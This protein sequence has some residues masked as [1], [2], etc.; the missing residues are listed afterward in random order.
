[1]YRIEDNISAIKEL[2]RLLGVNES[3]F[4]DKKTDSAVNEIRKRNSLPQNKEVDYETFKTIVS[5]HKEKISQ[6][7]KS[8]YLISPS[9]PYV[10][11][12]MGANAG[13]INKALAILLKEY[14]YEGVLPHGSYINSDTINGIHYLQ[15]VFIM[16]ERDAIDVE[17][18]NRIIAELIAIEIKDL[19]R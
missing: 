10:E 17:L 8:D 18:M 1:M 9:F 13:R 19:Y 2:Q 16:E 7:W 5:E 15:R 14:T 4:Y 3:G 11:N 6:Q 12:N